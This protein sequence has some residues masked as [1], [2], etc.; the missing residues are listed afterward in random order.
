MEITN[1]ILNG[2]VIDKLKELE[3]ESIQ[4][5]VTSPP[6][7]GLRN[8]QVD[9]QLGLEETPE[10]Y[11]EK[12]VEVFRE[13]KR[14][15][16]DNG[17]LWLNIGDSYAT[18]SGTQ[19]GDIKYK[20]LHKNMHKATSNKQPKPSDIGLKHK[21]LVGIPWRVAFALQRDGWYLR[22][23][24]IWHKPNP[25]PES[26]KDRCTKAHEYIFLLTKSPNYYYD[27]DAIKTEYAK[28]TQSGSQFGGKKGNSPEGMKT[29]LQSSPQGF[30][31][32]LME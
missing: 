12:M 17:T 13:V 5:V 14:V 30:F 31:K 10:K 28:G 21:D 3:S 1:V 23:D 9:G 26:V 15:L 22:Q 25:M 24:I 2:D 20:G 8:Y 16:K 18:Q 6:Y 19:G 11:V 27:S 4:C 29:K 7:W 32:W